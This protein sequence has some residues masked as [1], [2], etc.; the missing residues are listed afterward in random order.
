[1]FM[2]AAIMVLVWHSSHQPR[3]WSGSISQVKSQSSF[4]QM[5]GETVGKHRLQQFSEAVVAFYL[6]ELGELGLVALSAHNF[7][8]ATGVRDSRAAE[9][10]GE[11]LGVL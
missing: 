4:M 9:R 3:S 5:A 11:L 8:L 6:D 10:E 1:M 2:G 7:L